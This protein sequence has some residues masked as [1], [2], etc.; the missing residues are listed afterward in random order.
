MNVPAHYSPV[1]PYFILDDTD[2]FIDFIQKVFDAK[3]L[4]KVPD[5]NGRLMHAEYGINGGTIMFG[6][7]TEEWKA[8]TCSNFVVT[9]DVDGLHAKGLANGSEE[10]QAPGDYGYG[11]ASGF[12]DKFGNTLWLNTPD[13]Q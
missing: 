8:S 9:D 10:L 5:E 6:Q 7:C 3:E 1:M 2:G 4:L 12:K 11:R 13:E